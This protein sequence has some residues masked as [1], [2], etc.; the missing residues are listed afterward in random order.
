MRFDE[1]LTNLV[2]SQFPEF[3]AQEGPA[4]IAFVEAYY[5]FLDENRITR[6]LLDV[7]D[8]D[9]TISNIGKSIDLFSD[10]F[11]NQYLNDFPTI[12]AGNQAFILKN[13]QDFYKSKGSLSSIKL[14][15]QLLYGLDASV[16][17]PGND[18][19][20]ASDGKWTQPYYIEVT[21]SD[22]S[23]TLIGTKIKGAI[24][25]ATAF[26]ESVVRTRLN[27]VL[28]DVLYLSNLVGNFKN[29]EYISN[30]GNYFAMPYVT[31][32]LTT[33]AITDGAA[34][35]S[36][37]DIF[38]I[39]AAY[40]AYGRAR[41]V[42][43]TTGS[44]KVG[45]SLTDG[46][47]GY[48]LTS[49]I[50]ISAVV[51]G[52]TN[53]TATF[54]F[55]QNIIQP[56]NTI[57][58]S[59]VSGN[60]FVVGQN[61]YIYAANAALLGTGI[62]VNVPNTTV[63]TI[64]PISG[65]LAGIS[66]VK[67]FGNTSSGS[68][69]TIANV[70]ATGFLAGANSSYL[71]VMSVNNTFYS[72][73]STF[74]TYNG[75]NTA[76]VVSYANCT[77]VSAG[78][79]ANAFIGT[80]SNTEYSSIY[81]D[82]FVDFNTANNQLLN[83]R[84]NG[85]NSGV[86]ILAGT[87]T[88]T[89][90]TTSTTVT[91]TST[92]FQ[93]QLTGNV[94]NLLVG[95]V[96]VGTV[97]SITSN[98]VLTL[99]SNAS[100][101][102]TTNA[103]TYNFGQ[104]GFIGNPTGNDNTL[105]RDLL[106][107]SVVTIGSIAS[108][109]NVNPGSNYNVNP[110]VDAYNPFVASYGKQDYIINTS[111]SVGPIL[112][113]YKITQTIA[114][115][116]KNLTFSTSSGSFTAN[117]VIYQPSTNSYGILTSSNATTLVL[118]STQ[119]AF[120]TGNV[121]DVE[122]AATANVTVVTNTSSSALATAFV[123][124]ANSSV[125][126]AKRGTFQYD[127][128]NAY[129]IAISDINNVAAATANVISVYVDATSTMMGNNAVITTLAKSAT[130]IVTSVEVINSG[131]NY[132]NNESLTL[133]SNT[134][135]NVLM[136]VAN[137]STQGKGIGYWGDNSGKLNSSPHL[138][139]ND[140]Y[141]EFSYEVKVGMS[142]DKYAD[143]LKKLVHI[144]GMKVFGK[145]NTESKALNF[146]TGS[147]GVDLSVYVAPPFDGVFFDTARGDSFLSGLAYTPD[148][149]LTVT[150]NSAS[151]S[152]TTQKM[153]DL[154][155]T[156]GSGNKLQ[157]AFD[158]LEI[159]ATYTL[160]SFNAA[161]IEG[162]LTG[163]VCDVPANSYYYGGMIKAHPASNTIALARL[164]TTGSPIA[165]DGSG[166]SFTGPVQVNIR[167]VRQGTAL[168]FYVTYDATPE[169]TI[170]TTLVMAPTSYEL[171]RLFTTPIVRFRQGV[172]TLKSLKVSASFPNARFGIMGDSIAQSRFCTNYSDGWG[173]LLRGAYSNN[174]M[175]SGAPSATTG[176]W[177]SARYAFTKM[178]P[179][180][181]FVMLGTNDI[182]LGIPLATT[183]NNYTSLINSIIA[184]NSIPVVMTVPPNANFNT[185]ILNTWL[186]AQGWRYIDIF[187]L[188]LGTGTAMNATYDS[189]DGI[190]PNTAGNLVIYNAAQAYITAQ[191]L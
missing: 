11:K 77:S 85:A 173:Q 97:N 94:I 120:S 118:N 40:G 114:V 180:T 73:G 111:N 35:N 57:T 106:T 143:V 163:F 178:A 172:A 14:L 135:S 25:N 132:L 187:P 164:D 147:S 88:L 27:G 4:F 177:L 66:T 65:T 93:T 49:P 127:I 174:V 7:S 138:H 69:S 46:G 80:L 142:F 188:M 51:L 55:L 122:T 64:N 76:N 107:N 123:K 28:I 157:N 179:K 24:T 59:S 95:N 38:S 50:D 186:K 87:G 70:S 53:S 79:G 74:F 102:A 47:S 81:T 67:N 117:N 22:V 33:I 105:L 72:Y 141:Q 112:P 134:N 100:S 83:L 113:G 78:A 15:F 168:A 52:Y 19:L 167:I 91:G 175:V 159:D 21:A 176:N 158:Y 182:G 108:L 56:L 86:G 103:Y 26:V 169:R 5:D 185:P 125:I 6:N 37:G 110:F 101:N 84:L 190:H 44:G 137:V 128:T 148:A 171:P 144:S 42:S 184:A 156:D 82:R 126:Y 20:R 8:F 23:K 18:I 2:A 146:L 32:S 165:F 3:Y 1:T 13:I 154:S 151:F 54:Q 160:T 17:V 71:G 129:S 63:L 152:S 10:H 89:Y 30:N 121:T 162:F 68:Y 189:G 109:S 155:V 75:S 31:G 104:L 34:N 181:T 96:Y 145:V 43:T 183:Q 62:V 133:T 99:V 39:S 48:L 41:V 29:G 58:F 60:A 92:L 130:G 150:T 61:A 36:V 90:N 136:G 140:Y 12:T 45:F 124:S 161:D 149:S 166:Y 98:T 131:I 139:D 153:I 115:P 170:S 191:G 9:A 119:G 116:G 16:Y